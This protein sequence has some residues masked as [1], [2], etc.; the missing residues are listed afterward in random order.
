MHTHLT[1]RHAEAN[2]AK[3][4]HEVCKHLSEHSPHTVHAGRK[5]K[6]AIPD[7]TSQGAGLMDKVG[8]GN[9]EDSSEGDHAMF[10]DIVVEIGV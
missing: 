7:L 1:S 6:Y 5:S 4:F 9:I 8:K 2:M 10:E 3:T